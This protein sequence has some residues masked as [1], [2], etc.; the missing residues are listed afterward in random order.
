MC[1][2]RI[3]HVGCL[4]AICLGLISPL[5]LAGE[6]GEQPVE[7]TKK[8][9]REQQQRVNDVVRQAFTAEHDGWSADEVVL[10]DELNRAFLERCREHLPEAKPFDLNWSL[11]NLRK[12][13]KLN[14]PTTRRRNDRHDEYL[15]AAEIAARYAQDK[16]STT[17][18]RVMCDPRQRTLFDEAAHKI[19]PDVDA[20]R[21]RKAAFGLRKTRR[22]QP[23]LVV[24]VADWGKQISSH[25]AGDLAK[26]PVK[27]PEQPG[28][29]LFH[30]ATGYLY[31]GESSN[32]RERVS[33]HLDHS[34][35]KSLAH[36]LWS[37]GLDG[38]TVELHAFA[39]DSQARDKTARRAYESELIRSRTPRLNLAP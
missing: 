38:V 19:A 17:I 14:V 3:Q 30:D 39:R 31:I 4:F 11:L 34:D 22:L 27:I 37:N 26:S 25:P 35:R 33:K 28:I 36:Y 24:R 10:Q 1:R 21:L 12:A 6:K 23:E 32:L 20:Y 5:A 18:D 9:S 15:H 8:Q 16:F 29:Y 7:S 2:P 13:G